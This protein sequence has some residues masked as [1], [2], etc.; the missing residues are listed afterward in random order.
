MPDM[1]SLILLALINFLLKEAA[2]I[3]QQVV[4]ILYKKAQAVLNRNRPTEAQTVE[5]TVLEERNRQSSA[6]MTFRA[7]W[8]R[9]RRMW[10]AL[11]QNRL[12]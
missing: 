12:R 9:L 7:T 1:E 2:Q 11:L 6:R 4:V 5:S 3:V 10:I 8:V